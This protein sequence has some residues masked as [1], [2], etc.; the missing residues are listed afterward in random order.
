M[1]CC[2]RIRHYNS[3]RSVLCLKWVKPVRFCALLSLL[4]HIGA[5]ALT[6]IEPNIISTVVVCIHLTVVYLL[7][8][9]CHVS[10]KYHRVLQDREGDYN[11]LAR[12]K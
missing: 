7:L 5:F 4:I 11:P 6:D 1:G 12:S 8:R 10:V 9:E 2:R 3:T